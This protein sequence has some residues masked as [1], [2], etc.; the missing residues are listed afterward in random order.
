MSKQTKNKKA[1]PPVVREYLKVLGERIMIARKRREYTQE[2]L[3]RLVLVD[4]NTIGR[5]ENGDPG[6]SLGVFIT[7][8]W[9]LQLDECLDGIAHP[10]NDRLGLSLANEALKK[11]VRAKKERDEYNF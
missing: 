8:L 11:R 10:N 3:A 2:H 4:R 9:A 1:L 5:L 7:A 6:I